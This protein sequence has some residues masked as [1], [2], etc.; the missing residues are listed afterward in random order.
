MVEAV[1]RGLIYLILIAI[2]IFL[3]I[4]VL[5]II[6]IVIPDTIVKLIYVIGVLIALLVIYRIA[7][8]AGAGLP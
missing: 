3:V 2:C 8:A 6:G 4:W 5:G 1:I 7:K